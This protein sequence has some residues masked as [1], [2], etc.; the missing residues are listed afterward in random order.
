[1][2]RDRDPLSEDDLEPLDRTP[3]QLVAELASVLSRGGA[4]AASP[5]ARATLSR[6]LSGHR[7]RQIRARPQPLNSL[8]SRSPAR[9]R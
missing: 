6:L 2:A 3:V 9:A 4:G 5:P 7:G 1:M 8:R